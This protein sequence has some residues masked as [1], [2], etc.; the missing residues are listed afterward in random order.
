MVLAA[1][2]AGAIGLGAFALD[3]IDVS[4]SQE[5]D[6]AGLSSPPQSQGE[7][8]QK[9]T[10]ELDALNAG[11]AALT[12]FESPTPTPRQTPAATSTPTPTAVPPTATEPP[13]TETP[14]PPTETPPPHPTDTPE[15]PTETPIPPTETPVPPTP[16]TEPPT[17]TPTLDIPENVPLLGEYV[18]PT[19]TPELP[20]ATATAPA[21]GTP[22]NGTGPVDPDA[23][24][25]AYATRYADSLEGNQMACGGNFDQGNAF[26]VA[27]SLQYDEAWPC[28]TQLD[29][30]GAAGCITGVRTDTCPG[31]PGGDIDLSRAGLQEVCGNQDGCVV[32][33]QKLQ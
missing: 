1:L 24:V 6:L 27:V 2:S 8:A 15:P 33:I 26:V 22:R 12:D 10:A 16:T 30:C 19:P 23:Q 11:L 3:D 18:P 5:T 32:T 13:P 25:T 31:C 28:G 4:P 7:A 9:I 17:A 21:T 20:T 14:V 29:V